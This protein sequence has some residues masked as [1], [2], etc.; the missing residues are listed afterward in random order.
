ML[1]FT[2]G[3]MSP[4]YEVTPFFALCIMILCLGCD[5]K[6]NLLELPLF[7]PNEYMYRTHY[8]K[9]SKPS[10]N[11]SPEPK[12]SSI[13][14]EARNGP[15]QPQRWEIFAWCVREVM[16]QASG[17]IKNDAPLRDK[18]H[19]EELLGYKKVKKTKETDKDVNTK[20]V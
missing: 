15:H 20:I 9:I 10:T 14:I 1:R 16:S 6:V 4:T 12:H 2:F 19:Y 7:V 11:S 13:D 5:I 17:T 18:V 8:D 3:T